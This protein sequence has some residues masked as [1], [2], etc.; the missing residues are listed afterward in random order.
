MRDTVGADDL[1]AGHHGSIHVDDS[2]IEYVVFQCQQG[3]FAVTH[4]K[5]LVVITF[6]QSCDHPA[7]DLIR[8]ADEY[9]L[10]RYGGTGLLITVDDPGY[11]CQWGEWTQ[12]VMQGIEQQCFIHG[13]IQQSRI[14]GLLEPGTLMFPDCR[15]DQDKANSVQLT[16]IADGLCK[17]R[18]IEIQPCPVQEHQRQRTTR[19]NRIDQQGKCPGAGVHLFQFNSPTCQVTGDMMMVA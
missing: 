1:C 16:V 17:M 11:V 5:N 8:F 14:T 9:V 19:V 12:L 2:Q 10:G 13:N 15:T 3:L 6:Q 18:R 7:G 4:M